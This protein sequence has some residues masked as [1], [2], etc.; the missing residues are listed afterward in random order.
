MS[1]F[2]TGA[3]LAFCKGYI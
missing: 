1:I 2:Q 3:G